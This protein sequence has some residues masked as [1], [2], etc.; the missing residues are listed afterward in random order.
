M[1][2]GGSSKP[3]YGPDTHAVT[4]ETNSGRFYSHDYG[5]LF[6]LHVGVATVTYATTYQTAS[7][8]DITL[9]PSSGMVAFAPGQTQASITVTVLDDGTPEE[10]ELLMLSLLS[11]SG[12]AVLVSPAQATLVIELSDD[13]NGVFTFDGN[14]LMV[15]TDEGET[16]Q[17][18]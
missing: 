9:A 10:Q 16:V 11:V 2:R 7:P 13:P 12:D 6:G 8:N 15:G 1:K 17:L 14:S 4:S 5:T 18:M 3:A